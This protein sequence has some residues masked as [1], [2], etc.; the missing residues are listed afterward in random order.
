MQQTSL[1]IYKN[2]LYDIGLVLILKDV[3]NSMTPLHFYE[4]FHLAYIILHD[5]GQLSSPSLHL[6][7]SKCEEKY[8][9]LR[10]IAK[11]LWALTSIHH[12]DKVLPLLL[13]GR[14]KISRKLQENVKA[15]YALVA[16]LGATAVV[17]CTFIVHCENWRPAVTTNISIICKSYHIS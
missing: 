1:F 17:S 12:P 7:S 6:K 15:C 2:A 10:Q 3:N 4:L 9:K 16:A 14:I 13:A 11:H 8:E 5:G